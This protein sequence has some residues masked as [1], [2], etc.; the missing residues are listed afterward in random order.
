[1]SQHPSKTVAHLHSIAEGR[2]GVV[3]VIYGEEDIAS[4][5]AGHTGATGHEEQKR[6]FYAGLGREPAETLLEACLTLADARRYEEVVVIAGKGNHLPQHKITAD[7][8]LGTYHMIA[9]LKRAEPLAAAPAATP[10]QPV[11]LADRF[12]F[13]PISERKASGAVLIDTSNMN[14]NL[15]LAAM[16]GLIESWHPLEKPNASHVGAV[17]RLVLLDANFLIPD[18]GIWTDEIAKNHREAADLPARF[19]R[20]PNILAGKSTD[21]L[22]LTNSRSEASSIFNGN[23]IYSKIQ[24]SEHHDQLRLKWTGVQAWKLPG[25]HLTS[26]FPEFYET[27]KSKAYDHFQHVAPANPSIDRPLP[28]ES[29]SKEEIVRRLLKYIVGQDEAMCIIADVIV[30]KLQNRAPTD[31]R[32]IGKFLLPGPTGT[33]KTESAKALARALFGRIN[34]RFVDID[35]GNELKMSSEPLFGLQPGYRGFD[36]SWRVTGRGLLTRPLIANPEMPIIFL[37][38]ELSR[39]HAETPDKLFQ[40]LDEGHANDVSSGHRVS[41]RNTIFFFTTNDAAEEIVKLDDAHVAWKGLQDHAP[42]LLFA[43]NDKVWQPPFVARFDAVLPL[44]YPSRQALV[45]IARRYTR[46][47]IERYQRVSQIDEAFVEGMAKAYNRSLGIRALHQAINAQLDNRLAALRQAKRT[48][49]L[50]SV[51]A[52]GNLRE[53][54]E[55]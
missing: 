21:L 54:A 22:L 36:D 11:R 16:Y 55:P 44:C 32:P 13:K 9:L 3:S 47:V 33:G 50:L 29:F 30:N 2:G 34:N 14:W 39:A 49:V 46:A 10:A 19:A 17:R 45:E 1:M 27:P 15:R 37:I 8:T 38:D 31:E 51:T 52:E 20:L 4:P 48:G 41:F 43:A 12:V 26:A 18:K 53:V 23:L 7:I 35:G 24:N 5:H 40:A 42:A 28:L 25:A 6:S